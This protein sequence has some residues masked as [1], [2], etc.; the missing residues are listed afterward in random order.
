MI[1]GIILVLVFTGIV[2]EGSYKLSMYNQYKYYNEY[3][4][5]GKTKF[6]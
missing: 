4:R 3:N 5:N 6:V 2:G 1:S